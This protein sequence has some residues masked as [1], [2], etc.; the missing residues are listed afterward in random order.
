MAA[1]E[2]KAIA[3]SF[4]SLRANHEI[5][6]RAEAGT[7]HAI[8]GENGAGKST[9]MKILYGM[10]R[11]DEG[12]I[13]VDGVKK[14]WT[15][16][17]QAIASGIGM[18]HQHFMLAE[19]YTALENIVLGVEAS[20]FRGWPK[21]FS[22]VDFQGARAAIEGL[23]TKY[24]LR[25][26]LDAK[27]QDLSVGD[28]QRIEILKLLYRHAKILILD[29]PTAV[30]TPQETAELFVN[31]KRLCAEGK[32]V[33]I[34][35]HKLKEVMAIADHVTIFRAGRVVGSRKISETHIEELATL[36]VGRKVNLTAEVKA[37]PQSGGP[38]ALELKNITLRG[39]HRHHLDQ[40][41]FKI[42]PGE[43][44]G[45]AGVEGNGQSEL[46]R[47]LSRPE[48]DHAKMSGEITM[49]GR[50]TFSSA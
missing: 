35:T 19:P 7:L 32:T 28:Q 48:I 45:I 23:I 26:D 39:L 21:L 9:A 38:P 24:G 2:L 34:I 50:T 8:I 25:V 43:I 33:L 44:V 17:A 4:G 16:P 20:R 42:F 18:V 30:L 29:E 47:V 12:E 11:P 22:L 46:L 3:K 31:L 36:M 6:F 40:L 37:S 5:S 41:S 49:L 27:I 13:F 15:S 14:I 1:V 10:Y